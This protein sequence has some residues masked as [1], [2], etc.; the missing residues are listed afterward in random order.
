[1]AREATLLFGSSAPTE[2]EADTQPQVD[3]SLTPAQHSGN[4]TAQR[5]LTLGIG[6]I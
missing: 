1:V 2:A 4:L 5:L 3:R 6:I